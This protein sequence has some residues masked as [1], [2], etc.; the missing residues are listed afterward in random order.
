MTFTRNE[1]IQFLSIFGLCVCEYQTSDPFT[2]KC[3]LI[4][5]NIL[6]NLSFVTEILGFQN[7]DESHIQLNLNLFIFM[8]VDKIQLRSHSQFQILSK[9]YTS[10]KKKN[11]CS[12]IDAH[13]QQ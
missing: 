9:Q 12:F 4:I 6:T 2:T 13:S 10:L 1:G 11:L 3:K 8:T 5:E 7:S